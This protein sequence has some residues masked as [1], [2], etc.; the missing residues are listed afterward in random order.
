MPLSLE[1][2]NT[3]N[4]CLLHG[5]CLAKA[6]SFRSLEVEIDSFIGVSINCRSIVQ[7]VRDL[8]LD[9]D[10][11]VVNLHREENF[12]TAF[13]SH[14]TYNFHR[15]VHTL[16]S[17]LIGLGISMLHDRLSIFLCSLIYLCN[18]KENMFFFTFSHG[19][20]VHKDIW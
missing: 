4:W 20:H 19:T 6:L 8:L 2:R 1:R 5:L 15:G 12:A 7:G 3:N 17:P 13:L 10:L 9:F 14:G 16:E 18:K 11:V